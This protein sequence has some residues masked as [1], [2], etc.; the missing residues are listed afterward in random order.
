M[1]NNYFLLFAFALIFLL[2]IIALQT[3]FGN[4]QLHTEKL[5][6]FDW[7]L[8]ILAGSPILVIEEA[9]K[10]LVRSKGGYERS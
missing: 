5:S 10:F 2:Q 6:V 3:D 8:A 4:E 9:R 1:T 7:S